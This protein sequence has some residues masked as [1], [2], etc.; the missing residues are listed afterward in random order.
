MAQEETISRKDRYKTF[1]SREHDIPIFSQPWYL[2]AVSGEKNWDVC[3]VEKGGQIVASMPYIVKQK[4]GFKISTLPK[5]TQILGPYIKYPFGQKYYKKISWDKKIM[6]DI[7]NQLPNVSYFSQNFNSNITNWLPFFWK[8][9]ESS[10]RYTYFIENTSL[11]ELEKGL[12]NDVRRRQKKAKDHGVKIFEGDDIEKFYALNMNTFNR[13]KMSIHYDLKFLKNLYQSCKKNNAVKIFFAEHNMD[14][15]A[16]SLLV[17]DNNTVYYLLGGIDEQK[18]DLGGMDLV[19]FE[20]I[21]FALQ[22][23]RHFDFEGSMTESI[24]K[25]FRSFG[26]IQKEFFNISKFDSKILKLANSFNLF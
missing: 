12:E 13:K 26:A 17:Y 11:E 10:V 20:G 16:A 23:N 22:S 14:L 6:T 25:Y 8:D 21:K 15:I 9:F 24:E 2:D 5:L 19:L 4:Y 3:L 18:K 1:S 7:I